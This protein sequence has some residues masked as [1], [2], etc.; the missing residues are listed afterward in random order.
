MRTHHHTQLT[1]FCQRFIATHRGFL[2]DYVSY[3]E[4]NEATGG[5]E[6]VEEDYE[7]YCDEMRW[8]ELR[9]AERA[10]RERARASARWNARL[11]P[12]RVEGQQAEARASEAPQAAAP[13]NVIAP[14]SPAAE[15][16]PFQAGLQAGQSSAGP[17]P[18]P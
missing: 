7:Q 4:G 14:T 5:D 15:T 9:E 17:G 16:S 10:E 8:F 1:A 12:R 13:Q 3:Y 18:L 11:P 6:A 2:G